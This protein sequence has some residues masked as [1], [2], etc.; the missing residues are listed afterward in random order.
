MILILEQNCDAMADLCR[1]HQV[2]KLEVFGSASTGQFRQESSDLDF[3]VEFHRVPDLNPAD[4]Y[5][6]F[7]FDLEKL[8][9]RKID[10]IC[11]SAMKNPYFIKSV[12]ATRKILYAA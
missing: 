1:K 4:Q 3:L 11:P 8:F 6:G 10:L 9:S 12:N 2:A 5:F 7:L